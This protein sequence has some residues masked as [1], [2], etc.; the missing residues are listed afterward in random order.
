MMPGEPLLCANMTGCG[1]K[2]QTCI[3]RSFREPTLYSTSTSGETCGRRVEELCTIRSYCE[4]TKV[5]GRPF[6]FI[7]DIHIN[8]TAHVMGIWLLWFSRMVSFLAYGRDCSRRN[9]CS[10]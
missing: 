9:F 2:G 7:M 1:W 3:R 5:A 8:E 4:D 6:M 10:E